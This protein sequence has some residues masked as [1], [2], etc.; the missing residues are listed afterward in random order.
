M[1]TNDVI[2]RDETMEGAHLDIVAVKSMPL[3]TVTPEMFDALE[4]MPEGFSLQQAYLVFDVPGKSYRLLYV[5]LGEMWSPEQNKNIQTAMF[6]WRNPETKAIQ[7]V[8]HAGDNLVKQL[9]NCPIM[10][11]GTP[12]KV[13]FV[14]KEKANS[15]RFFNKF[16]VVVLNPNGTQ[17]SATQPGQDEPTTQT[18]A[19][20][21]HAWASKTRAHADNADDVRTNLKAAQDELKLT[22][23]AD[24][25]TLQGAIDWLKTATA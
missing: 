13:T 21:W 25:N 16:D 9:Q 15:G 24:V 8:I 23:P 20:K 10:T 14:G 22:K 17:P 3:P 12:V 1:T 11:N 2:E 19:Q 6:M 18:P 7:R 4:R 5:G